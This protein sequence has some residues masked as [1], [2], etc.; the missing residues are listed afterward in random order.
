MLS[1]DGRT[2]GAMNAL[3][4]TFVRGSLQCSERM[5]S[6]QVLGPTVVARFDCVYE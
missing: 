6:F 5:S 3:P 2:M 1:I 4:A